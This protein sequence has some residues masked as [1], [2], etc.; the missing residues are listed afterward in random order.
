MLTKLQPL[1]WQH[2]LASMNFC[3][4]LFYPPFLS[5]NPFL[6]IKYPTEKTTNET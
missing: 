6:K 1:S 5:L 3:V 4:L 2:Q